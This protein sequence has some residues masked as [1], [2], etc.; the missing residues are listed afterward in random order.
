MV[1][2]SAKGQLVIPKPYRDALALR[3]GSKL[4]LWQEGNRLILVPVHRFGTATK[5][6]AKGIYGWTAKAIERYLEERESW[7]R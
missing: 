2:L 6:F 5:G 1:R 7:G 4:L 3:E